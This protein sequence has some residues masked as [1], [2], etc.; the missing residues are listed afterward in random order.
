MIKAC[1]FCGASS[2]S[3]QDFLDIAFETGQLLAKNNIEV[4]FGGGALG[5]MGS[6]ADGVLENDGKITGVIPHFLREREPPHPGVSDMRIVDSMHE[7]KSLMYGMTDIF[8]TLPGGFGTLEESME[9]ITWKQ[10]SLHEK[11]IIFIDYDGFWSG[12]ITTFN[13][14]QDHAFLTARDR[15]AVLFADTPNQA[16]TLLG[17]LLPKISDKCK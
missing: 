7:R 17:N 14:M 13:K 6:L 15:K 10:L 1:V 16:I 4:I 2:K 8:I 9:V 12:L 11:S 5:M 3:D